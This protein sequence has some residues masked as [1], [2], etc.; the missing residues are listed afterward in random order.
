MQSGRTK[1]RRGRRHRRRKA[2]ARYALPPESIRTSDRE[3][4]ADMRAV[5]RRLRTRVLT[6][7]MYQAHGRFKQGLVVG[8]FGSWHA[9]VTRAGLRARWHRYKIEELMLNIAGV[10]DA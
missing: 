4:L 8:R 6:T 2:A 3:L 1:I 5:A 7:T 9:A 10:W